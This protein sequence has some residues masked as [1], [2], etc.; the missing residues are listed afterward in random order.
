MSNSAS[1]QRVEL[2][3]FKHTFRALQHRNF[4]LFFI[5]QIISWIGTWM[6]QVAIGW[7]AYRLS[8]SPFVLGL[9]TFAAQSPTFFLSPFSGAVV[10]NVSRRKL[11]ITT[12][13]LAMLQAFVLAYLTLTH[14]V[15][16]WHLIA[17][18]ICIGV[19]NSF[20]MPGRQSFMVQ[21]VDRK[22]DLGNAIALNSSLVNAARL[23][24]PTIAGF[25]IG[26]VGEGMCFAIN[27]LTYIA[28]ITAL[29][30]MRVPRSVVERRADV[31]PWTHMQEGWRYAFGS[32]PIRAFILLLGFVAFIGQPFTV[33]MPVFAKKIFHGGPDTLGLLMCATGIGSLAGAIY[34]ASRKEI[35]GLGVIALWS[36]IVFGVGLIGLGLAPNIYVALVV[37]LFAGF[38]MMVQLAAINTCLQTI[39]DEDKRGRIMSLYT[40]AFMTTP[41]GALLEG[42]IADRIGTPMVTLIAGILTVGAGLLF[43]TQLP[44]LRAEVWRIYE[45]K[46]IKVAALPD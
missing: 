8:G 1:P 25:L 33:L 10:D 35:P 18:G 14:Q 42:W 38:G 16:I 32:A 29:A 11:I 19:I 15:Q 43:A 12:Q 31:H 27:G 41:F 39:V 46:G 23:L 9:V 13:S 45:T 44:K 40:M 2:S 5:G 20:D 36:T 28:V 7:L 26:L 4:R 37:L 34:L 24:G 6:Q 3:M 22:E 30:M 21:M 17:L